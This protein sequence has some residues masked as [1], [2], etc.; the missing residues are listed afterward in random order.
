MYMYIYV[1]MYVCTVCYTYKVF[2][3]ITVYITVV[4]RV[5]KHATAGI[6]I[7]VVAAGTTMR[8]RIG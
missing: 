3:F 7:G 8:T 4:A 6:G 2:T 1:C 5:P